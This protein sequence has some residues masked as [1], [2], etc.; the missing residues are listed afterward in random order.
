MQEVSE[1]GIRGADLVITYAAQLVETGATPQI[2]IFPCQLFGEEYLAPGSLPEEPIQ[3]LDA[4]PLIYRGATEVPSHVTSQDG[5]IQTDIDVIASTF[6]M[7]TRYEEIVQ[8]TQRDRHGRF[9]ATASLAFRAGF[10]DRP[11]VHEY[12]ELVWGWIVRLAPGFEEARRGR[13][14]TITACVSH[15]VDA[16]KRYS[17]PPV[18]SIARALRS[19]RGPQARRIARDYLQV[20]AGRR[21][22]RHDTFDHLLEVEQ[23]HGLTPTFY[24]MAGRYGIGGPRRQDYRLVDSGV[25]NL[26]QRL[27]AQGAEIGLHASYDAFEDPSLLQK[28][29]E[30]LEKVI[31]R[32]V[33]GVRQH[34]L[35]FN[36]PHSWRIWEQAGFE[37]DTT[38]TFAAREGFRAGLCRPYRPFDVLQN[39]SLDI[40]EM[41]LTVMEATLFD[42]QNLSPFEAHQ[43]FEKTLKRVT[44]AG[45]VFVL[46]WHNSF[47]EEFIRPGIHQTYERFVREMVANSH[48]GPTIRE[49]VQQIQQQSYQGREET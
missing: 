22:N 36:A 40:W 24:F 34:Y 16:L 1:E 21:S 45:G 4:L 46:L 7:A 15:D 20:L 33:R 49:A 25:K 2:H 12:A 38:L 48:S 26:I 23:R 43:R 3:R 39:Q 14:G 8:S 35:R 47:L 11:I 18:P 9:P 5:R 37:Y 42:Y 6:F 27:T 19:G 44:Q 17:Y 31:D 30:A 32:P 41:P 29:K 28:E 13:R 10:L